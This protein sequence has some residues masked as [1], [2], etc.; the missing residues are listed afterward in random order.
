[1]IFGSLERIV[2]YRRLT[3]LLITFGDWACLNNNSIKQERP[4]SMKSASKPLF[5][6]FII[7]LLVCASLLLGISCSLN[8][9][10]TIKDA[11]DLEGLRLLRIN[12]VFQHTRG[13]CGL[14]CL[15]MVLQYW[16]KEVTV[17]Q[18]KDDLG[19]IRTSGV[20]P[21]VLKKLAARH[22]CFATVYEGH[23]EDVLE[24][25]AKGR[26]V[27]VVKKSFLWGKHYEVIC[28]FNGAREIIVCH[29]PRKGLYYFSYGRLKKRLTKTHNL[30]FLVAL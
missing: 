19:K 5:S 22:G 27:I 18:L 7:F 21:A 17:Q 16:G 28:G 6:S 4:I 13:T 11:S 1:M 24:Q 8:H 14:A 30:M 3:R 2:R 23:I 10:F 12:P 26:P 20:T 25:I 29:N 9:Q 15:A